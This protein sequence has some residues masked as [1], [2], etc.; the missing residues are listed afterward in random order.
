MVGDEVSNDWKDG[1]AK[2]CKTG[3]FLVNMRACILTLC[4]W[5]CCSGCDLPD[6]GSLVCHQTPCAKFQLSRN[7]ILLFKSG[8]RSVGSRPTNSPKS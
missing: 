7:L 4:I 6:G 3:G 5:S 8:G 2:M 1:E